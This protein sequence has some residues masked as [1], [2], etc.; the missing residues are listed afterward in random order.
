M[1]DDDLIILYVLENAANDACMGIST[2]GPEL[3]RSV[4]LRYAQR[5]IQPTERPA[6]SE[7]RIPDDS[8]MWNPYNKV[9]QSHRTGFI[10]LDRTNEERS[11]CGL[12]VPWTPELGAREVREPPVIAQPADQE[13]LEEVAQELDQF[14]NLALAFFGQADWKTRMNGMAARLRSVGETER[15]SALAQVASLTKELHRQHEEALEASRVI[16]ALQL[17]LAATTN[18]G[19]TAKELA[20]MRR[21]VGLHLKEPDE[22]H[23]QACLMITRLIAALKLVVK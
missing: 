11:K 14:T 6:V 22:D 19:I 10:D 5:I 16:D 4:R 8:I 2:Y 21:W 15:P 13:I 9:V 23:R 7:Q 3:L 17:Q 20:E 18:I 1:S 12:P